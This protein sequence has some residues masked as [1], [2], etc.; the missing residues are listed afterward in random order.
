MQPPFCWF[1]KLV[2]LTHFDII[3][4]MYAYL[5]QVG[6]LKIIF[7]YDNIHGMAFYELA[8]RSCGR[9]LWRPVLKRHSDYGGEEKIYIRINNNWGIQKNI[10][11]RG[12]HKES[13]NLYVCEKV[14]GKRKRSV[15][16]VVNIGGHKN[17]F[18]YDLE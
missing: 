3:I 8:L 12:A 6:K 5:C 7:F 1:I 4:G 15:V 9:G 17:A 2:W 11:I 10:N 13:E 14:L 16:L 18:Y